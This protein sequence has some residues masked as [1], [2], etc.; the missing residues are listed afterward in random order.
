[1]K[2]TIT[3][4]SDLEYDRKYLEKKDDEGKL[5][6]RDDGNYIFN[7]MSLERIA[8]TSEDIVVIN[9][10]L[11]KVSNE[12]TENF[13]ETFINRGRE[14]TEEQIYFANETAKIVLGEFKD[15]IVC[16]DPAPCGYGKSTIKLEIMKYLI[17]LYKN[18]LSTTGVI[19][20]GDRLVDLKQLQHDLREDSKYTFLLESWNEDVCEDKSKKIAEPK[21]CYKCTYANCKIK[22]QV[23]EQSKYPILLITNARLKEFGEAIGVYKKWDGGERKLLLIDERPQIIDTVKV[24]KSLMNEIDTYIS[25]LTYEDMKEK[26]ALSNYWKEIKE[27][28]ENKMI[29]LREKYKRFIISNNSNIGV[30]KENDAFM[31]LWSKYLNYDYKKESTH[32]HTVLTKGGFYVCE[33]NKEFISTIG[34]KNLRNDYKDFKT[35][36][37]DGSAL[38]DPQYLSMYDEDEEKSDL[39]FLYIPNS[40]TYENLNITAYTAHKISKTEFRNKSKYLVKAVA[41]FVKNKSRVGMSYD[42]L[43]TYNEQ[44]P[45]LGSLLGDSLK[46]KIP[47]MSDGRTYYFGNTK[48]SN[49]M[50]QCTRMFQVG[51][52]TLPDYEVAIMWLSCKGVWDKLLELCLDVNKA[53]DYSEMLQKADR[54]EDTFRKK[55][56]SSG[57]KN[58]Y[59]GLNE[60]DQ[61][62]FLDTVSKFYQE[63]HRTKLRDYSYD[64]QVKIYVFQTKQLIYDMIKSLLPC[65]N[66]KANKDTLSEFQRAKDESFTKADGT[67]T[68][69]Q[70]FLDWNK[71]FEGE[72]INI[73]EVKS[74][75]NMNNEEWKNVKKNTSVK[76]I[77]TKYKTVREGKNV[78]VKKLTD[79]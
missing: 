57:Y 42:Y 49:A 31:K 68:L 41:E 69:A 38:Y 36:I 8:Y 71:E 39:K 45:M 34:T 6:S 55:T 78:S 15:N 19:I 12:I 44:S 59:F 27:L 66:F 74:I 72:K 64:G 61:F 70:K 3:L 40:R 25:N 56:Y 30:C 62:Q 16:V 46:S 9:D 11:T 67:K 18:D 77:L 75:C 1:M 26:T 4:I 10:E 51:W 29:P 32:I 37:F 73:S 20:V 17:E 28:I 52:D 2:K 50:E 14:A 79:R 76:E 35:I 53:I 63:I 48:G 58:Y 65:C 54:D 47:K 23:Y 7:K 33:S 5:L 60:I 24:T 13:K 21:I 43:V 22:K